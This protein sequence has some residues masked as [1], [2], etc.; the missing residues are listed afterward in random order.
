MAA[1]HDTFMSF[2]RSSLGLEISGDHDDVLLELLPHPEE[3]FVRSPFESEP[4]APC[5]RRVCTANI[6]L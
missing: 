4:V 6:I 1:A 5:R 2:F 3:E